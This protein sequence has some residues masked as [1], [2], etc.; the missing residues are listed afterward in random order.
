MQWVVSVQLGTNTYFVY[1][2]LQPYQP[3]G[4]HSHFSSGQELCS[5][6]PCTCNAD[7]SVLESGKHVPS[8]HCCD[9]KK[10]EGGLSVRC[11]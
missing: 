8:L 2:I 3:C 5:G 9:P 10:V 4:A 1:S 6:D 11:C 7:G